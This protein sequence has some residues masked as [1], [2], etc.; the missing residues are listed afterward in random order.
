MGEEED[1]GESMI[2]LR[3]RI[4]WWLWDSLHQYEKR[5]L[6]WDVKE[7]QEWQHEVRE[8]WKR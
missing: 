2:N 8:A 7:R 5:F 6:V 1:D 3:R 4:F